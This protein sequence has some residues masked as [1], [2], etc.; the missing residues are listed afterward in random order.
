[1]KISRILCAL[2]VLLL[3]VP[4]Y[5]GAQEAETDDNTVSLL[6]LYIQIAL[7]IIR[8]G[9]FHHIGNNLLTGQSEQQYLLYTTRGY[10]G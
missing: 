3:L 10:L 9:I 8:I 4:L 5:A 7:R 6:Y 2:L 1:M